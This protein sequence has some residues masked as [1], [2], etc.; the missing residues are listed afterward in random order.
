MRLS[1]TDEAARRI[2]T[3][4]GKGKRKK[5]EEDEINLKV[6]SL[7]KLSCSHSPIISRI[8]K[9]ECVAVDKIQQQRL[10]SHRLAK[11]ILHYAHLRLVF[12]K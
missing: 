9:T 6:L 2:E 10:A 7:F 11:Y 1:A 12:R 8:H 5:E 4:K 3:A